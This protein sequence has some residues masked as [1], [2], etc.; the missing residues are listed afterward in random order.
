MTTPD[1]PKTT[2]PI[3][4]TLQRL[5]SLVPQLDALQADA[6]ILTKK[7]STTAKTAER[8]GSK[9]RSLDEEMRRVREAG[10]RVGLV[11][12]L[13]VRCFICLHVL[14]ALNI[15]KSSLLALQASVESQDWE[16]AARHCARAMAIPPEIIS[17]PF[18]ESVVVSTVLFTF[19][20]SSICRSQLQNFISP[21]P[22]HCRLRE[23][24][25]SLSFGSHSR[26]LPEP[27]IQMRPADSSSYS[28]P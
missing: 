8:V 15:L 10:D 21:L 18:A 26:R 17:G 24:N 14:F 20:D 6:S 28:Q 11:M 19:Y 3:I 9:V 22:R 25:Y 16:S 5:Q 4:L 2:D 13:K 7:V 23:I 27:A 12:D 1:N